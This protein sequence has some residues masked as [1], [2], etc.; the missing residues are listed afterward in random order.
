MKFME[1]KKVWPICLDFT[2]SNYLIRNSVFAHSVGYNS[3]WNLLVLTVIAIWISKQTFSTQ[4]YKQNRTYQS[5]I[6]TR[7]YVFLT[8]KL[9]Y[10]IG[11]NIFIKWKYVFGHTFWEQSRILRIG[12]FFGSVLGLVFWTF[13]AHPSL[14]YCEYF[15]NLLSES[16]T[17]YTQCEILS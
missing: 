2:E 7:G 14:V 9:L 16:N 12:F 11:S 15:K 13:G 1:D 6:M 8:W 3:W 10:F 17:E 5:E 4:I